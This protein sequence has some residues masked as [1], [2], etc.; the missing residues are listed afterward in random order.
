MA[1]AVLQ[2][3]FQFLHDHGIVMFGGYWPMGDPFYVK[4]GLTK[5][6]AS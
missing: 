4:K 1:E 3:A 5:E 2:K 6:A